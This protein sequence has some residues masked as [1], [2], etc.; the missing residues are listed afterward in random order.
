MTLRKGH[1]VFIAAAAAALSVVA[2][3]A[4]QA[5]PRP[6]ADPTP[7]F[8]QYRVNYG[9]A[10]GFPIRSAPSPTANV[11]YKLKNGSLIRA[12][13]NVTRTGYRETADFH[14]GNLTYLVRTSA[15]CQS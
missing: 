13:S 3:G 7:V 5:A 14:W 15:P 12:A 10:G 6:A 8:C 4:A 9:A 1:V 11:V 2:P